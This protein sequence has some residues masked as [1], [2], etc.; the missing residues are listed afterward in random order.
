MSKYR[1]IS[2]LARMTAAQVRAEQGLPA[3]GR[4]AAADLARLETAFRDAMA[5]DVPTYDVHSVQGVDFSEWT[6]T[7]G[8]GCFLAS[9]QSIEINARLTMKAAGWS[10]AGTVDW[11]AWVVNNLRD[12]WS[13]ATKPADIEANVKIFFPPGGNAAYMVSRDEVARAFARDPSWRLKL[14]PVT[15]DEDMRR[16]S[17]DYGAPRVY[18][19]EASGLALLREAQ[20]VGY[21]TASEL[22]IVGMLLNK[23]VIDFT[24]FASECAGR[25]HPIYLALREHP[26]TPPATV[27]NRLANC[28]WSGLVPLNTATADAIAKFRAYKQKTLSLRDEF[29][30]MTRRPWV[31]TLAQTEKPVEQGGN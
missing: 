23:P 10:G 16:A 9:T 28:P 18:A 24:Y 30:P 8:L 13:A 14:H 7:E 19:R 20:A 17:I 21:T 1:Y 31:P 11:A 4:A 12:K 26:R 25:Y 29:A 15:T 2:P 3:D 5:P 27:I 22:G 6:Y